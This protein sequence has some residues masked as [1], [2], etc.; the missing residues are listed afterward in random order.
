M[1]HVGWAHL[2]PIVETL[3]ILVACKD[4]GGGIMV[5]PATIR[6]AGIEV[7]KYA[8]QFKY[9]ATLNHCLLIGECAIIYESR[10]GKMTCKSKKQQ[11]L[12]VIRSCYFSEN[13]LIG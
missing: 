6:V 9:M 11:S 3:C 1:P 8:Q 12:P 2:I 5:S 7:L 10:K 4:R 13:I